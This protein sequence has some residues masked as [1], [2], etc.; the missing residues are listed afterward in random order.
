MWQCAHSRVPMVARLH[1]TRK[2][3]LKRSEIYLRVGQR[4][5]TQ[6]ELAELLHLGGHEWTLVEQIEELVVQTELARL[7]DVRTQQS[8][9]CESKRWWWG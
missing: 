4:R 9:L 1:S 6:H 5:A 8:Q 3:P 2:F 7:M